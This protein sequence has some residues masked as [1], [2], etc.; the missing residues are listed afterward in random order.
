MRLCL[1][2]D[3]MILYTELSIKSFICVSTFNSSVSFYPTIAAI[4]DRNWPAVY[5]IAFND[6]LYTAE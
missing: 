4:F 3:I 6:M 2:A 1:H 5:T